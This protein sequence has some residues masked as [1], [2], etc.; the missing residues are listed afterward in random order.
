MNLWH[1]VRRYQGNDR[2]K[3]FSSVEWKGTMEEGLVLGAE[4]VD[5]SSVDCS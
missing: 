2:L 3:W 4:S 5:L 1:E